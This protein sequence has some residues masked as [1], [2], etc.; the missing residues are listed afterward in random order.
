[1]W[2]L[3]DSRIVDGLSKRAT[4]LSMIPFG[5]G[6]RACAWGYWT[7]PI[8]AIWIGPRH[9]NF[10]D[11][12]VCA[13]EP[14][15]G[16]W[17]V[18]DPIIQLLDLYTVWALRHL[19]LEMFDRWPGFQ[20]VPYAFERLMELRPGEF[21]GCDRLPHRQYS[22][23]CQQADQAVDRAQARSEFLKFT[24]GVT[25]RRPPGWVQPVVQGLQDLVGEGIRRVA[26]LL[27][28]VDAIL[29]DGV[30]EPEGAA[31][32]FSVLQ[33][34]AAGDFEAGETLK[35]TTLPLDVPPPS[36]RFPTSRFCFT[37]TFAFGTRKECEAAVEA[38]GARC[39]SLTKDTTYVVIGIYATD[40][41]IHSTFGRKIEKAV[42]MRSKGCPVAIVG[43]Q[44][45]AAQLRA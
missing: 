14:K 20:S 41:W 6:G 29:A 19:H 17:G 28:R 32:L 31:D 40:S 13:F 36:I 4:L 34:F 2:L 11:G 24:D 38:K 12:S 7:T 33:R 9:T 43:E 37:G 8:S 18:G 15:D 23:C 16:T 27:G 21:C 39:G 45:W 5:A 35:A 3:T 25:D 22:D 44:H 30:V 42:E 26:A 1:M 10:P